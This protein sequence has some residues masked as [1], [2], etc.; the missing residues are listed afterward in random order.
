MIAARWRA[1]YVVG[2]R[3]HTRARTP[4]PGGGQASRRGASR[5]RESPLAV[6]ASVSELEWLIPVYYYEPARRL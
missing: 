2:C 6:F 4:A 1:L 3:S 5:F